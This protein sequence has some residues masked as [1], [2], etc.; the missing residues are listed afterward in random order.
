M[1]Y[2]LHGDDTVLSRNMLSGLVEGFTIIRLD[3]KTAALKEMEEYLL[4]TGLFGEKKA[5]VVESLLTKNPKK[6]E[7]VKFLNEVKDSVL[8][9]LWEDKKL[10]KTALTPL[11][12][13]TVRE[14]LLPTTYFQF[15]DSFTERNGKKLF[16]MY[17][18]LLKT[19][20]A[21]QV[22]YSLLKRLRLLLI[23]SGNGTSE[24]LSKMSPWQ[25][26][27][28]SQQVRFWSRNALLCFYKELQDT[29]IKLKSGKLPLG[30]SKHLDTLILSQL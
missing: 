28:L 4:S 27:K 11:K 6:K 9:V 20:S 19:V 15:L 7:L 30:L 3:G 29:E 14:F 24:G 8:L 17:Q 25:K 2:L 12:N 23:M 18:E 10:P 13:F 22:F 16:V 26:Q 1:K 5:V 21:E